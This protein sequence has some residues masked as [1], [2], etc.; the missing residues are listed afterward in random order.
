MSLQIDRSERHGLS[1]PLR[2]STEPFSSS[3]SATTWEQLDEAS[4][5]AA[6]EAAAV[7]F[8]ISV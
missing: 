8:L 6:L 2:S 1:R 4:R 3:P 5:I 7:I